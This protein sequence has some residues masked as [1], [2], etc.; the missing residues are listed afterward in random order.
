MST[1][2][3]LSSSF[4]LVDHAT[5]LLARPVTPPNFPPDGVQFLNDMAVE[6]A[7]EKANDVLR[8]DM[9]QACKMLTEVQREGMAIISRTQSFCL[10]GGFQETCLAS[11]HN[12]ETFKSV[13][14]GSGKTVLDAAAICI[15]KL[16]ASV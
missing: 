5:N 1:V 2:S 3:H 10:I 6:D 7:I 9:D 14:M 11:I 15:E 16:K 13:V 4:N 12:P 8:N